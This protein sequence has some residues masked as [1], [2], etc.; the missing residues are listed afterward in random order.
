MPD[1]RLHLTPRQ[2]I[3]GVSK[4]QMVNILPAQHYIETTI[5]SI[6]QSPHRT[7]EYSQA[8][9]RSATNFWLKNIHNSKMY[10]GRSHLKRLFAPNN[11]ARGSVMMFAYVCCWSL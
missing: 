11:E 1:F 7:N 8:S 5:S 9:E 6:E 2:T 3:L 4:R 10:L